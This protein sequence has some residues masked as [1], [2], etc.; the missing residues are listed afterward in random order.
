MNVTPRHGEWSG[1]YTGQ[2]E[3]P[4]FTPHVQDLQRLAQSTA[5]HRL[6]WSLF[7]RY[8]P[9]TLLDIGCNTGLYSFLANS[10]GAAAIGVDADELAVDE[11]YRAARSH[12]REVV[13]GCVDFVTPLRVSEYLHKPRL[14]P[15]HARVRSDMVLCLAV[16]H[17]WVFKR[18]QLQFTDV[19]A[20]LAAVTDRLLVVE[21]V[22]PHDKY[23]QS[24]MTDDHQWYSLDNFVAALRS[25]FS[26]IELHDSYPEPRKLLVCFK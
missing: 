14:R 5:K 19:V 11:M 1:Y 6:L 15:L 23:I 24:W 13:T 17:H 7:D 22:P 8:R 18:T 25:A 4:T 12:R 10:L 3:L 9:A 2:N 21:F 26:R 16:V 20:I